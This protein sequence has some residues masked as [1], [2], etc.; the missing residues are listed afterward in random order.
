MTLFRKACP[1][2]DALRTRRALALLPLLL[3]PIFAHALDFQGTWQQGALLL[4]RAAPGSSILLDGEPVAVAED[5]RFVVALGR[6]APAAVNLTTRKGEEEEQYRFVVSQRE[7]EIQRVEGVPQH[8]VTP[9][10][11]VLERIRAEAALVRKARANTGERLDLAEGFVMP[12]D[13]PITGVYG[14]QR[15]YNGVPR[16]PHYGLDIAAPEGTLVSAPAPGVVRLVHDDM[17]FSGGTLIVDHGYG[18][19]ST[20]IHLSAILV[21]VGDR[22]EVGDAIARVGSTGRATGPHLDW[23]MNWYDV[24]VDPALVLQHFPR[25]NSAELP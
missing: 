4:G 13:G 11:S 21:N 18:V 17:Y 25:V 9:P 14:S 2:T 8:T 22:I 15:F 7:Y 12:L 20:F 6:D 5:G 19:S 23:R 3:L 1:H 16:N 24:R 10:E